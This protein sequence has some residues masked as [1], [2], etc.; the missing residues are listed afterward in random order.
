M[1]PRVLCLLFAI[2]ACGGK[3]LEEP[4]T[5]SVITAPAGA[6]PPAPT[7]ATNDSAPPDSTGSSAQPGVQGATSGDGTFDACTIL[8]DRD[9]RCPTTLPAIPTTITGSGDCISRCHARLAGKCG[10]DAWLLCFASRIDPNACTKLPDE[11]L[12]TYCAWAR[13]AKQPVASCM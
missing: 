1:T 5:S 6:A 2:T 11:C 7:D 4:S 8:C 10:A 12:D 13:C 9:E 3:I